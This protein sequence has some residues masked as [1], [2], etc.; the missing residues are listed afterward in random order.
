MA[1]RTRTL[2]ADHASRLTTLNALASAC[3][4]GGDLIKGEAYWVQL[5]DTRTRKD[6]PESIAASGAMLALGVNLFRQKRFAEAEARM[7][8][9]LRIRDNLAP[10]AWTT[11]NAK[12][13]LG[14]A[15]LAQQ[16]YDDAEPLLLSGYEGIKKRQAELPKT[17]K[18]R[19]T[20]AAERLVQ[21]YTAWGKADQADR[22]QKERV[23]IKLLSDPKK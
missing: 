9:C 19:L 18:I 15:L 16:K 20:E 23:A 21:L 22:W 4:A 3:N 14:D 5:L 8:A 6:G 11:F 1:G 13:L 17:E 10:V 12:S 7:R 2:G